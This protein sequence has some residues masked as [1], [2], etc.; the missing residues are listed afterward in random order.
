VRLHQHRLRAAVV[1]VVHD[2]HGHLHP[3]GCNRFEGERQRQLAIA[4]QHAAA[5]NGERLCNPCSQYSRLQQARSQAYSR[6]NLTGGDV[7]FIP[8]HFEPNS[9]T[10]GA[11]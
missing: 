3:A 10:T 5:G 11:R 9:L 4:V 1:V 2:L 7:C 6:G 8:G